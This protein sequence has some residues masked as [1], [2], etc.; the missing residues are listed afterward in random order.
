MK[1]VWSHSA[2]KDYENCPRKYHEVRVLKNFKMKETEQVLYG[3]RLHAAAEI[4]VKTGEMPEEFVG[5]DLRGIIDALLAKKG[6]VYVEHKMAATDDIEPCDWLSDKVW[7]RGI[8]DLLILDEENKTAW[9]V[10]Y[11]TGNN[12]YPDRSQ[13]ELMALLVFAH[14]NWVLQVNAALIFVLKN[15]MVKERY[16]RWEADEAWG[17][18]R[19][20][21]ARI[22]A[23]HE[24]GVWNPQRSGLCG[25]CEVTSCEMNPH[26]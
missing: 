24:T 5:T 23:A 17:R 16:V 2:L 21:V 13:L 7:V 14:F 8:A 11:K 20:R 15:S 4:Y 6:G 26:S 1:V 19:E 22:A 18:Y 9:V 25:W 10:D 12:K 3:S